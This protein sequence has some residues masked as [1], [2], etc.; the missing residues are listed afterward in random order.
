M[1]WASENAQ[2]ALC[3]A[4][5][6]VSYWFLAIV[7]CVFG[8]VCA[9]PISPNARTRVTINNNECGNFPLLL[10]KIEYTTL[11]RTHSHSHT[12]TVSIA[13]RYG[14][15]SCV[16]V[17]YSIGIWCMCA[18]RSIQKFNCH[19]FLFII[20]CWTMN[21]AQW[22]LNTIENLIL[23][24][25]E[26]PVNNGWAAQIEKLIV[27]WH[28]WLDHS[29]KPDEWMDVWIKVTEYI[30]S[31]HPHTRISPRMSCSPFIVTCFI[32]R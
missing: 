15:F 4:H 25:E 27:H 31:T 14:Q 12:I 3:A 22:T 19:D 20:P 5:H 18:S 28:I 2:C 13:I 32:L 24:L 21:G 8:Y 23:R 7:I 6:A 16:L 1:V 9:A 29:I 17:I 11:I 30:C 26:Q 10:L